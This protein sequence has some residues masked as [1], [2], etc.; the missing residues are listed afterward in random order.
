LGSYFHFSSEAR[1]YRWC[2]LDQ[3]CTLAIANL[4]STTSGL[5]IS[6]TTNQIGI[7]WQDKLLNSTTRLSRRKR[8]FSV[9]NPLGCR[10]ILDSSKNIY[11]PVSG[12][13]G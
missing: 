9:Q 13:S 6:S 5:T 2:A 1:F 4:L 12:L 7:D 10:L 11:L 3:V 8:F